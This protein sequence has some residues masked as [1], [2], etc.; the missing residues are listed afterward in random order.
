MPSRSR[1]PDGSCSLASSGASILPPAIRPTA[2]GFFQKQ[3]L[4]CQSVHLISGFRSTVSYSHAACGKRTLLFPPGLLFVLAREGCVFCL[5]YAPPTHPPKPCIF[6]HFSQQTVHGKSL[7]SK[8]G[9]ALTEENV[10][11]FNGQNPAE[12]SGDDAL[13]PASVLF[14]SNTPLSFSLSRLKWRFIALL[15]FAKQEWKPCSIQSFHGS[16]GPVPIVER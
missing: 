5:Q 7:T 14:T 3:P 15:W 13:A 2:L 4:D 12:R 10:L 16:Y 1:I 11:E 8:F 9:R 6:Q